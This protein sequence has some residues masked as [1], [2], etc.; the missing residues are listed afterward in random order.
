MRVCTIGSGSSGNCVYVGSDETHL[1]I[2][3]G[4]SGK[5]IESGLNE[6]GLTGRDIDA[7]LVTH[8][9]ID[10]ISGLGVIA[11]RLGLPIYTAQK[12]YDVIERGGRV[13]KIP[14]GLFNEIASDEIF[15]IGDIEIHSFST[16]HDAADPLGFRFEIGGKSF[17]VATDL[18]CYNDYIVR[19]LMNLDAVLVEANHDVHML[20][21]GAY[22]YPLKQRILGDKGHLSNDDAGR[23]LECILH[24]N[25]KNIVLGHLSKENNYPA[26]AFQTVCNEITYGETPYKAGDFCIDVAKRDIP[27]NLIEL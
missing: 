27:G 15:S 5:K 24:D 19:H 1:L 7:V 23:L 9:H 14:E 16:S 17:A 26:L 18:G 22:P 21:A 11:R 25:L 20:E 13:G 2:D 3:A 12:T 8:E 10:H 4:L 6:L